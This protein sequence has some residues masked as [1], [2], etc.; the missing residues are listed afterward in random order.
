MILAAVLWTVVACCVGAQDVRMV[1]APPSNRSVKYCADLRPLR[2]FVA[3]NVEPF[4]RPLIHLLPEH[5]QLVL[6]D[7]TVLPGFSI[8][9]C[10]LGAFVIAAALLGWFTVAR[11]LNRI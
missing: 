7:E 3:A 4:T 8:A 2:E 6:L 5:V 10:L 11:F 1:E 9:S